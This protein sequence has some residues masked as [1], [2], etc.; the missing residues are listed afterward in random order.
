MNVG[1][2]LGPYEIVAEIGAGGMGDVYRAND[3]RLGRDVAIKFSKEQ[4]TDRFEREARAIAALN[5]PNICQIYDVGPNYLVMEFIDGESP[6]GP[7]PLEDALRIATQVVDALEAAHEKG[8]VHRDLKPANIKVRPDGSVKVLDFGLATLN[9]VA[10]VDPAESPTMLTAAGMILGTA[11]YMSPEQARGKPVDKRADIWA[12][13]VVL[14]EMLSG[15]RLFGGETASDTLAEVLKSDIDCNR[16]PARARPLLRRCLERDPK[17]RLRDI[18]EARF[19]FEETLLEETPAGIQPVLPKSPFPWIAAAVVG[20]VAAAGWWIAYRATRPVD[21]PLMRLSV[22]MGAGSMAGEN[23]TVALSPDGTRLVYAIRGS[24][25]MQQLATRLLNQATVTSLPGTENG[26]GPFFSPDGAWIGF[27]ADS[28]LKKIPL[29]GGGPVTLCDASHL[30]GATWGEDGNILA[31][32]SSTVSGLSLIPSTGGAPRR[33]TTPGPG[34]VTHRWPQILPDGNAVLFTTSSSTISFENGNIDAFRIKTGEKKTVVR[35]GYFG[36]YLPVD[37]TSGVLVYIHEGTLYGVRFDPRSLE[38]H[39]TPAA[40]LEDIA[41]SP[42][43]GAAQ[44]AFSRTGTFVYRN[45]G[46]EDRRWPIVWLDSSGI[47]TPL[48][49][50]PATYF[51]P[52]VSPD[53]RSLAIAVDSGGHRDLFTYDWQRDTMSRLTSKGSNYYPV[54]TPDGKHMAFRYDS[55]RGYG[56]GWIRANGRGD[57]QLLLESKNTIIPN[58]FSPGGGRLAY[59]EQGPDASFDL[60]TLP[61]D[62]SAS[63]APK[64]AKPELFL[65]TSAN[66]ARPAFSPDGR[67]MAY[68]S[69]ESGRN[70]V[71]VRPFPAESSGRKWQISNGGGLNQI[72]SHDG[73]ELYFVSLDDHIMVAGYK[74]EGDSF[75]PDKPRLWSPTPIRETGLVMNLDVAPD[76]KRFVIFPVAAAGAEEKGTLRVNFLLNYFDELRRRFPEGGR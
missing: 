71:Y 44:F 36:R 14:F 19:F 18:G 2:K 58:S 16:A 29:N 3:P 64:P 42:V 39:G 48:L 73:R 54:W 68:Y 24:D 59:Q 75:I 37:R 15:E 52:R 11:A 12:F 7:L 47:T 60:W 23:L 4:F 72:W 22:D 66:E 46:E 1:D 61:L 35:G 20:I 55:A 34:E 26:N 27:A 6:N 31:T 45:G 25:G 70:E 13:G 53:G 32:L 74:A 43:D 57:P 38:V 76:G 62:A 33:L 65:H 40:L 63:D 17:R 41:A 50:L 69:D 21:H 56:I 49:R 8:I 9:A 30:S 28:K 67:W 10:I 5:H 51:T